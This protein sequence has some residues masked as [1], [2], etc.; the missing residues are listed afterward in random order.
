MSRNSAGFADFFPTAPSVL[1]Q[2]QKQAARER[3]R[4]RARPADSAPAVFVSLEATSAPLAPDGAGHGTHALNGGVNGSAV[5]ELNGVAHDDSESLQGDLLNGVGSASSHTSTVSSTFSAAHQFPTANVGGLSNG[6]TLT[7][8]TNTESSPPER[9]ISPQR[10]KTSHDEMAFDGYESY[11]E[12]MVEDTACEDVHAITPVQT[13]PP[14]PLRARPPKGEVKGE[15]CT[16]DPEL[17]P[18]LPSKEKRKRKAIYKAFGVEEAEEV[19]TD[20]RLA[21]RDYAKGARNGKKFR[22][23]SAPYLLKPYK[24]DANSYGPEPPIQVVVTGF[25]PLAPVSS[26][27]ALFGTFGEIAETKNQINPNTGS[28]LGVCL[29]RYKDRRPFRGGAPKLAVDAAK[30]AAEEG[31][32][33]RIGLHTVTVE[34]DR[35]GR[36]CRKYAT[37][38][39]AR[40]NA[41]RLETLEPQVNIPPPPPTEGPPPEAPK[42]PSGKPRPVLAPLPR[43]SIRPPAAVLVEQDPVLP[44]IKRDPYIFIAHC[45]VPVLGTTIEHLKKRLR[46]FQLANVRADA[47]GYYILFENS[48]RGEVEAERCFKTC[49]LKPLFN[50]VMNMECQPYGNPNYERSPS[51]E[52]VRAEQRENEERERVRKEEEQEQETERRQRA[53]D[54]DPVREA[55]DV[56]RREIRELLLRDVRAKIAA[57]AL[58]DFLDPDD[59]VAKRRRFGIADTQDNKRPGIFVEKPEDYSP[60]ATPDPRGD[61]PTNRRIP[62][63]SAAL[64]ITALP[65]IRKGANL[66]R[67]VGFSDPFG[68]RKRPAPKK[69]DVRPLYHRLHDFR[70]DEE[71]SDDEQR[72]SLAL[73][74]EEQD[75]RSISRMSIASEEPDEDEVYSASSRPKRPR[76]QD[77]EHAD[78]NDRVGHDTLGDATPTSVAASDAKSGDVSALA[79]LESEAAKLPAS[80]RKR[81]KLLK[82]IAARKRLKE[83]E[84]LFNV[85]KELKVS[86]SLEAQDLKNLSSVGEDK[87]ELNEIDIEMQTLDDTPISDSTAQITSKKA[88]KSKKKSKKQLF[89]ER[90]AKKIQEREMVKQLLAEPE[91]DEAEEDVLEADQDLE[92]VEEEPLR[93]EVEWGLSTDKPRR[94][95]E[96][97]ED[98]VLDLDGWQ[99]L[100]K[101]DEDLR[102]LQDV[103]QD[104][105][106][107][108]VGNVSAWAWKQKEIKALNRGGERGIVH[109]ETGIEGYYLANKTGSART[110]G[111][112]K[113]LESEKSKYLPHRIKV[114]KAREEREARAKSDKDT[115]TSAAEAAKLAAAKSTSKSTSRSTRVNNRRLVADINAQKQIL[116][117]DADVL[118]F[119]QLKKRKKPVKFARSAIHNWGLYAMENIAANDMIIEY[120]GEMVRQ[121]VADIRERKYLKS[122][123]G[124]SYLFRIDENTVIDA[125]KRGGIARFINHSCT[126]N[127]TAKI[128]KVEGSKRIVIYAL[129]DIAL[130]EELTYDYKFEREFDSE[131]RIPCLCGSTG[132]KGFLN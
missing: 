8:L 67:H 74:A 132:C 22:L 113:I 96:D 47:T 124:S 39:I 2:K 105:Q 92:E 46:I 109:T 108:T 28:F 89:E 100:V 51:P 50:Y 43:P 84:E 79:L 87:A 15:I 12:P 110:E 56:V 37:R 5:V 53:K 93:A 83:D 76:L 64:N 121:Q 125:T 35:E 26:I 111:T 78:W 126:P 27:N 19:V 21:I 107:A 71:D 3:Q 122:G 128:I 115:T 65:R 61:A 68:G 86:D 66:N 72:S 34:L 13:P 10:L 18:K 40:K 60:A 48:R 106:C 116:S 85:D 70:S 33:Q 45:Y 120:V 4:A 127:C 9:L 118:R 54:L 31:T 58:Y 82:E 73:E 95:V 16:Y 6:P 49:H 30:K 7:P 44:Q 94:T 91:E 112:K 98:M 131:D 97:D 81:T 62:L 25:D 36:L 23:R 130:N 57:P 103:L 88:T 1:Q 99:H 69:L 52:R 55:M 80:S 114:Q 38:I 63:S 123:I 32:G 24:H 41:E 11:V 29:V 14:P 42:G 90:E 77:P 101:D 119:N 75:S 102:Y 17:D 129:R 59:H 104:A 117:G 20:P